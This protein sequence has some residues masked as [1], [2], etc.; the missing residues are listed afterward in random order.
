MPCPI[1]P[2][3]S[4]DLNYSHLPTSVSA[5]PATQIKTAASYGT[6]SVSLTVD[7]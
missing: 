6:P 7:T 5:W 2:E 1:S 3:F 4:I